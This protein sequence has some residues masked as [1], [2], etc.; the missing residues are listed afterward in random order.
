MQINIYDNPLKVGIAEAEMRR[1]LP[2]IRI[3]T[4]FSLI[5]LCLTGIILFLRNYTINARR[6]SIRSSGGGGSGGGGG[7]CVARNITL[8]LLLLY[9]FIIFSTKKRSIRSF[10]VFHEIPTYE[11]LRKF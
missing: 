9:S 10:V 7:L 4:A 6:E 2:L 5:H 3:Q 1:V 11:T 8:L